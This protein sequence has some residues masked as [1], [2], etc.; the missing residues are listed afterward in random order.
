MWLPREGASPT[1]EGSFG[2][3]LARHA[4]AGGYLGVLVQLKEQGVDFT[5]EEEE[6]SLLHLAFENRHREIL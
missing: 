6:G 5:F 2:N 3:S 4:V 1:S